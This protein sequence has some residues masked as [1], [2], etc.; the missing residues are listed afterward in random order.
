M[1]RGT[2]HQSWLIVFA[3]SQDIEPAQS[4]RPDAAAWSLPL[5]V[6]TV[7]ARRAEPTAALPVIKAPLN[8]VVGAGSRRR[9]LEVE[10]AN[11]D[12]R[13]SQHLPKGP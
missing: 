2:P 7:F 1:L 13:R 3:G 10:K 11:S 4:S 5:L 6:R 9:G 8:L 12:L